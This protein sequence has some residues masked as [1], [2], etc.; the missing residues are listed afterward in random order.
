MFLDNPKHAGKRLLRQQGKNTLHCRLGGDMCLTVQAKYNNPGVVG[1]RVSDDI[2]K[3][4]I[5]GDKRPLLSIA[6]VDHAKVRLPAESLLRG[7]VRIVSGRAEQLRKRG[8][9]I[10]V[11]LE[12]HAALVA[13]TRSR[14]NSAA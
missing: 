5:Q 12:F 1:R 4:E 3:I 14:A 13:T 11:E 9:E 6:D 2:R 8:R 7:G 10:L